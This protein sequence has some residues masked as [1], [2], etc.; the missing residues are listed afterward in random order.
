MCSQII[1]IFFFLKMDEANNH[2]AHDIHHPLHDLPLQDDRYFVYEQQ[3]VPLRDASFV[4]HQI[5]NVEYLAKQLHFKQQQRFF[6][7]DFQFGLCGKFTTAV[8]SEE[9]MTTARERDKVAFARRQN[10]IRNKE[11]VA[12]QTAA[13]Q[14]DYDN[15]ANKKQR[16]RRKLNDDPPKDP[17]QLNKYPLVE[18]CLFGI[19]TSVTEILVRLRNFFAIQNAN[20]AE[21]ERCFLT[22]CHQSLDAGIK[23]G[24]F[25]LLQE[26]LPRVAN[27]LTTRL[28]SY[29]NSGQALNL[30]LPLDDSFQVR[31]L[32]S[33][34]SRSFV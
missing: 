14:A 26:N 2:L 8:T 9:H 12:K 5:G 18:D 7:T 15:P 17:S 3:H 24:N 13:W 32:V 19:E 25:S 28:C 4:I 11:L 16:K 27:I 30:D 23:I 29:L 20:S 6:L 21:K 10:R 33:A 22:L 34:K 31:F 1:N